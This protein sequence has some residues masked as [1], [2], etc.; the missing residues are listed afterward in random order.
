MFRVRE[1][2]K[3]EPNAIFVD[4]LPQVPDPTKQYAADDPLVKA[5]PYYFIR[6]GE[7]EVVDRESVAIADVVEQATRAPGEKRATRRRGQS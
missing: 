5:A 6:E 1:R 4:G 7:V 2:Y 3:H